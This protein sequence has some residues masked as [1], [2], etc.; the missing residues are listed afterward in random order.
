VDSVFSNWPGADPAGMRQWRGLEA[1]GLPVTGNLDALMQQVSAGHPCWL[2]DRLF[3]GLRFVAIVGRLR[4]ARANTGFCARG[5]SQFAA[6]ILPGARRGVGRCGSPT[7][8]LPALNRCWSTRLAACRLLVISQQ[9]GHRRK[10][11]SDAL[12]RSLVRLA[13]CGAVGMS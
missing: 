11:Y 5:T 3:G 6:L 9:Q 12:P 13:G 1:A 4:P 2:W 8:Q 10:R 7:N